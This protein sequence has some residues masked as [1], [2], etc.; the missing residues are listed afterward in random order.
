MGKPEGL[1]ANQVKILEE[2]STLTEEPLLYEYK[3]GSLTLEIEV[4]P[5][6]VAFISIQTV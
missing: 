1:T 5:L 3:K 6:G 2:V 4:P